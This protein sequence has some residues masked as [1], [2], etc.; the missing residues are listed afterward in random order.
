MTE[1]SFGKATISARLVL[2]VETFESGQ[3]SANKFTVRNLLVDS[4]PGADSFYTELLLT[5]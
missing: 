4:V 1:A 2:G 3:C 5:M